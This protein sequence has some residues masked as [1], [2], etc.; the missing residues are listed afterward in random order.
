M[1]IAECAVHFQCEL[2][3]CSSS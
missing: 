2:F 1:K 3:W